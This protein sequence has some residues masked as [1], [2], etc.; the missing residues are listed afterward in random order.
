MAMRMDV[1]DFANEVNELA[2]LPA[3]AMRVVQLAQDDTSSISDIASVIATDQAMTSRMLRLAN[4]VFY[5]PPREIATVRDAVVFLGLVEI[6]RL[7]L[8]SSLMGRFGGAAAVAISVPAFWGHSFA[9]G[10]VAEV[11][12]R[13]TRLAPPEEAFTAGILHDI[14]KLVMNQYRPALYNE[15]VAYATA[16]SVPLIRAEI[17]VFGFTHAQ[18]GRRLAEVWRLPETLCAAIGEH[19]DLVPKTRGV[20]YVVS[21]ANSLCKDHG[22]WCGF[23]DAE[24]GAQV[25]EQPGTD[26]MRAA[27]LAKLGGIENIV[28]RINGFVQDIPAAPQQRAPKS[29]AVATGARD[30]FAPPPLRQAPWVVTDRFP[31]RGGSLQPRTLR[32]VI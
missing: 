22:L 26:P 18:L 21:H 11:M 20:S 29:Q 15:A 16:H 28:D 12:A 14:G 13:Q 27:A 4:S 7:A 30:S 23:E 24:P 32:R 1:H 17:E 6:R 25:A 8:T 10:M 9:V 19:D 5:S 3:M 31:G 2:P